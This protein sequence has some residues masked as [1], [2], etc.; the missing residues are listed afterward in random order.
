MARV[1][2]PV[3]PFLPEFASASVPEVDEARLGGSAKRFLVGAAQHRNDVGQ[4]VQQDH[5]DEHIVTP[6]D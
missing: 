3:A 6:S 2:P 5:D 1:F 4:S